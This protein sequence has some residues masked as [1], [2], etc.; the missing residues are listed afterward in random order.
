MLER[1]QL[2]LMDQQRLLQARLRD[3]ERKICMERDEYIFRSS[4]EVARLGAQAQEL[5]EQS[6]QPARVL[7]EVRP[8]PPPRG[9]G[10]GPHRQGRRRRPGLLDTGRKGTR[11]LFLLGGT[12]S[13]WVPLAWR[14]D[15]CADPGRLDDSP[16]TR[17]VS[18]T[19]ESEGLG[20]EGR[21]F[22]PCDHGEPR[23][24]PKRG[25]NNSTSLT[26]LVQGL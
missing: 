26:E 8:S 9:L 16:P 14:A 1:L 15:R 25:G 7:L 5:R 22:Q 3:L 11:T 23:E 13:P 2:E 12:A 4:E 17:V 19:L 18:R 21:L 20:F 6:P 24:P 10:E